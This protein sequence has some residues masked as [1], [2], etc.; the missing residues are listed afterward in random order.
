MEKRKK[1]RT[2]TR[3]V[4]TRE[5]A[6]DG[7]KSEKSNAYYRLS[8]RS[9]A[10]NFLRFS[11]FS[12]KQR[13]ENRKSKRVLAMEYVTFYGVTMRMRKCRL[14]KSKE[15]GG[16][17]QL[18]LCTLSAERFFIEGESFLKFAIGIFF[19]SSNF[20][21]SGRVAKRVRVGVTD[22]K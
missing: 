15:N 5:N 11:T 17:N 18:L 7:A 10:I 4:V 19:G 9:L 20:R 13:G 2:S 22:G 14:S 12:S 3:T 1:F 21:K 6:R 16:G 8:F